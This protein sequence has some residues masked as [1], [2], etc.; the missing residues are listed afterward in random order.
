MNFFYSYSPS[1]ADSRRAVVS[2]LQKNVHLVLVN[3]L[4]GLPRN[5]VVRVADHAP[6]DLKGVEGL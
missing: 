2:Y 4:G 6:I 5:G 1:S 3:G